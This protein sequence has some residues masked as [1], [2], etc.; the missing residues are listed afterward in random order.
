VPVAP[1][2]QNPFQ[3]LGLPQSYSV[4]LKALEA[5]HRELAKATHPDKFAQALPEERRQAV[6]RAVEISEAFRALKHPVQ[7][8]EVLF[9]LVGIAT[10]DGQEP[11]PQPAFLMAVLEDREALAEARADKNRARAVELL[12][13]SDDSIAAVAAAIGAV[14]SVAAEPPLTAERAQVLLPKLGE[15]RYYLRLREEAQLLLD[16]MD[17]LT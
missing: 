10:G 13:Q 4:D 6:Q 17:G 15:L 3:L 12:A 5:S 14:F 1:P 7:R 11:K 2:R 16:E 9:E 8:A